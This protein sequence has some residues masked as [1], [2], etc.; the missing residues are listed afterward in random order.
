MGATYLLMKPYPFLTLNHLT[1]P[2]T[3]VAAKRNNAG[4][5]I[6]QLFFQSINFEYKINANITTQFVLFLFPKVSHHEIQ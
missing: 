4:D 1:V 2:K 3:F 6:D 5:I